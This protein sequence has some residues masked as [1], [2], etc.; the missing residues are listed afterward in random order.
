MTCTLHQT[1][2][3]LRSYD[4]YTGDSYTFSDDGRYF[5]QI[6]KEGRA[7]FWSLNDPSTLYEP[8]MPSSLETFKTVSFSP[9]G[10]L[11]F[12]DTTLPDPG[13]NIHGRVFIIRTSDFF[14]V[15]YVDTYPFGGVNLSKFA[16]SDDE[17]Y[18]AYVTYDATAG[19]TI[20]LR[21]LLNGQKI[22][23]FTMTNCGAGALAFNA[24][25]NQL[26]VKDVCRGDITIFDVESEKIVRHLVQRTPSET[27]IEPVSKTL[28]YWGNNKFLSDHSTLNRWMKIWNIENKTSAFDAP[29]YS[30]QPIITSRERQ[31]VLVADAFGDINV[32]HASDT[33]TIYVDVPF[34]PFDLVA[35]AA[36]EEFLVVGSVEGEIAVLDPKNFN[37][38]TQVQ[39]K[40]RASIDAIAFEDDE[41]FVA[42]SDTGRINR[43]RIDCS[44]RVTMTMAR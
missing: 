17:K 29:L 3:D 26:A 36:W 34:F 33:D 13:F 7:L 25:G 22:H 27:S 16:V 19:K 35:S 30:F 28:I 1:P 9:K 40:D 38:V 4:H 10:N 20:K 43:F 2:I 8:V 39:L 42:L 15:W 18:L 24:Q 37:V 11:A 41:S 23:T 21:N 31:S 44:G 32:L 5:G 6:N 14:P 12:L